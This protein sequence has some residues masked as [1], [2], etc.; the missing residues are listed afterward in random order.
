MEGPVHNR[1]LRMC[2][3][4]ISTPPECERWELWLPFCLFAFESFL[5]SKHVIIRKEHSIL[6]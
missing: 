3:S 5:E 4:Q 1:P 6:L 2:L